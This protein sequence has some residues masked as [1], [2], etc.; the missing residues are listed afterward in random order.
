LNQPRINI[1]WYVISDV[2]SALLTWLCFYSLRPVIHHYP[3]SIPPG[4]YLGGFLYVLGWISLY[5]LTGSYEDMYEKSRINELFRTFII[6]LIGSVVLLF[7]FI[8]KNPQV[9]N[10][11]YYLEFYSLVIPVFIVTYTLR[12]LILTKVKKQLKRKEVFFNVLLIGSEKNATQFFQAFTKTKKITRYNVCSFLHI[13]GNTGVHLP[14]KIKKYNTLA[15]LNDIIVSDNIEEVIIT[16]EKNERLVLNT[17]LQQLS[18]KNVNIKITPDAVDIL[19]GAVQIN[20]VMGLPLIDV[21]NG[22]LPVWKKNIK[23]FIDIA[24]SSIAIILL[25]PILLYTIIRT[26][27]SSKGP[28]LFLQD[29]VGFKGKVFTIYKFR[30]MVEDAEKNGPQLSCDDDGRITTWGRTMRKWRLDELP[31]LWNILKGDMSLVGPRPERKFYIDQIEL[32]HPEYN[33]LFKVKPGLTS[34]G[35]VQYGYASNIEEM[36]QRM[37][38]DLMYVENVSIGLDLK[39]MLHTIS[40]ILA[41]K[42]K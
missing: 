22:Q 35:M 30:S 12:L 19:S 18:D 23:R 11:Y 20:S 29:R 17:I 8:L 40:I 4:F 38:Y 24:F 13:N 39:I 28:M 1:I 25:S 10:D 14:E 27:F 16:V 32:Q 41:G 33:Y 9:N 26:K 7:F 31:Q 37:S 6:T 3:F 42:G 36:V 15:T 21:H 34:W 5:F 2:I